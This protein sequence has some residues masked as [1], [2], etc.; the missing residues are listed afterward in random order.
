MFRNSEISEFG[1][2]EL[3]SK[4]IFGITKFQ[5]ISGILG[6]LE[7]WLNPG[8]LDFRSPFLL[9]NYGIPDFIFHFGISKIPNKIRK[10]LISEIPWN[11]RN[12]DISGIYK[13]F[14]KIL[15]NFSLNVGIFL[16]PESELTG[17][18]FGEK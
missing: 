11:F 4:R 8:I 1:I 7:F 17:M 6:F 13:V 2:F 12:L 5:N 3:Q 15:L 10:F 18:I 16:I 9:R 14:S